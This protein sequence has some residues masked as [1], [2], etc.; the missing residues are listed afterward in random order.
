MVFHEIFLEAI[1]YVSLKFAVV[2]E[3]YGDCEGLL[4]VGMGKL[5]REHRLDNSVG[6]K[7]IQPEP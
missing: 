7:I 5:L 3:N 2:D 1:N 4:V 6:I